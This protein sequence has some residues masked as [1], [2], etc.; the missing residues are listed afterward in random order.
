MDTIIE[1]MYEQCKNCNVEMPKNEL[2]DGMCRFC[3]NDPCWCGRTD[4]TPHTGGVVSH[5]PVA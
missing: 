4:G 3:L 2:I 5:D 1:D